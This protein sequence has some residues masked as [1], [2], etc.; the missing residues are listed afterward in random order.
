MFK[1]FDTEKGARKFLREAGDP[2]TAFDLLDIRES[3]ANGKSTAG[4]TEYDTQALA[5][6]K[7]LLQKVLDDE[8]ATTVKDL[9]INGSDLIKDGMKAGPEIGKVLNELLERVIDDPSINNRET[10]MEMAR[11]LR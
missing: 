10:L 7:Q 1:Y 9:A 11:K 6:S 3:D 8:S 4:M 2:K 5:K